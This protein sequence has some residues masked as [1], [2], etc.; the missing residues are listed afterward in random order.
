MIKQL[1]TIRNLAIVGGLFIALFG[2]QSMRISWLKNDLLNAQAD[3]LKQLVDITKFKFANE[4][5]QTAIAKL[6]LT[7]Q[8]CAQSKAL[9]EQNAAEQTRLQKGR[10]ADIENKYDELRKKLP[11]VGCANTVIDDSVLSLLHKD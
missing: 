1:L 3:N 4:S 11:K 7:N 5:N 8:Q 10:I 6:K 2:I 9:N